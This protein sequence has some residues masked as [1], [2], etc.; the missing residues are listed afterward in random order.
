M[1][2]V[3]PPSDTTL[4][5]THNTNSNIHV[6]RPDSAKLPKQENRS[7]SSAKTKSQSSTVEFPKSNHAEVKVLSDTTLQE[8]DTTF[9][10]LPFDGIVG[11]G[12][13]SFQLVN[14]NLVSRFNSVVFSSK[15]ECYHFGR[16]S[17][18]VFVSDS[19]KSS[20]LGQPK[21]LEPCFFQSGWFFSVILFMVIGFA[22]FR[23]LYGKFFSLIVAGALNSREAGRFYTSKTNQF[24]Q[25]KLI[26]YTILLLAIG[27]FSF[28]FF[29]LYDRSFEPSLSTLFYI[30]AVIA[31][32]MF[33][34]NVVSSLIRIVS[35]E[36][37]YFQLHDYNL[38]IYN[39][40]ITII[41]FASAFVSIYLPEGEQLFPLIVGL[42]LSFIVLIF[43]T[44]R[45]FEIFI[46]NRFSI[47]YW[48]L[49]F[50]ALEVLPLAGLY[51]GFKRL[52]IIA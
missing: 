51:F 48:I 40:I 50:C 30:F 9:L 44:I 19:G 17:N 43:R 10:S 25:I 46:R 24:P 52:V 18:Q 41:V 2:S 27:V 6:V 12:G 39:F 38:F 13:E 22:S 15:K 32:Y 33:Y 26:T 36:R 47:F 3:L 23:V 1:K 29:H 31:V 34:R 35:N 5:Q 45:S 14:L 37:E 16:F 8:H 28:N 11:I 20:A 4:I 42:T 7:D 21:V 49:Y